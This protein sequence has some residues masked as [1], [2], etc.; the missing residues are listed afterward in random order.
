MEGFYFL[1]LFNEYFQSI[2][3]ILETISIF[4]GEYFLP[5]R[6]E[7]LIYSISSLLPF[8]F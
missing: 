5:T 6:N 3:A 1:Y 7:I 8:L 4:R 2:I